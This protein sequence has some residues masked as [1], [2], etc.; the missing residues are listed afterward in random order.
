MG[1]DPEFDGL[2]ID[3]DGVVWIGPSAVSGSV[4]AL[5]ELRAQGVRIVFLT[6]DPSGSRAEYAERLREPR[7]L[8]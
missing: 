6:N 3:L 1:S 7:H 2:V 5:A 4:G 8:C